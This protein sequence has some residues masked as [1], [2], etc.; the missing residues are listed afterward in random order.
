MCRWIGS[1][2]HDWSDYNGAAS[3]SIELLEWGRAFSGF[4]GYENC[5]IWGIMKN[6]NIRGKNCYC[7][8]RRVKKKN[9]IRATGFTS[10]S[11]HP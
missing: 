5:G 8:E 9:E 10:A 1:H 4:R 7:I 6:G 2:F 11:V 3:V